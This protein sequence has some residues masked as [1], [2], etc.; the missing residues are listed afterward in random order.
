MKM[1]TLN[2]LKK[3]QK[4]F[5]V[6]GRPSGP[7]GKIVQKLLALSFHEIGFTNIVERAVQGVDID[8]TGALNQKF[9]LE[10]KTTEKLSVSLSSDNVDALRDRTKDGYLPVIAV[11]RLS[12][13]EDW[14]LAKISL[15]EIPVGEV[16][17]EKLRRY[18][19]R[20]LESQIS[21][22]FDLVVKYHF[23]ETLKRGEQYL[24]EQLSKVRI[25]TK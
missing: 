19:M 20:D 13:L 15:E 8:V 5:G 23:N 18:R 4:K 2:L 12:P 22:V 7:F 16:L 17:I 14:I 1:E 11:L 3:L 6:K 24:N 9:A 21:S 25:L 10:V